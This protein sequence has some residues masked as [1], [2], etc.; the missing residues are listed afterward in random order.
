MQA[1]I[2]VLTSLA[3]SA[4]T[5]PPGAPGIAGAPGATGAPGQAGTPGPRGATGGGAYVSR[6][7]SYCN[8]TIQDLYVADGGVHNGFVDSVAECDDGRDLPLTGSC[9]GP[10][11]ND[12]SL[13]ESIPLW[14]P[15][16]P[17][18]RWGCRWTFNPGSPDRDVFQVRTTICCVKNR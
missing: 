8:Q 5:A 10:Q 1:L 18:A 6:A 15:A 2:G 13:T 14:Y 4:C 16:D 11:G 7:D 3:L 9:A 17:R 12:L